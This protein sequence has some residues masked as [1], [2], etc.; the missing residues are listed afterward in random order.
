MFCKGL[1]FC[2]S[3]L[4]SCG[5]SLLVHLRLLELSNVLFVFRQS[6]V[7]A[8]DFIVHSSLFQVLFRHDQLHIFIHICK[9]PDFW[10][11]V[12]YL[13]FHLG[14]FFLSGADLS[15]QFLDFVIEYKLELF[16]FL[17]FA[18]QVKYASQLVLNG[19]VS[20]IDFLYFALFIF[21]KFLELLF[22]I[23]DT[24]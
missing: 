6:H 16:Q 15:L 11:H 14:N 2:V 1:A 22:L 21:G 12:G 7:Q 23:I 5:Y 3:V 10:V 17:C 18:L 19:F 8:L 24:N 4:W 9:L 13:F 20:F